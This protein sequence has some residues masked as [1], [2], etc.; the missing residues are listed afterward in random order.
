MVVGDE[1]AS[2]RNTL[3]GSFVGVGNQGEQGL[4]V[5]TMDAVDT[6]QPS[7]QFAIV[8]LTHIVVE[9]QC[10]GPVLG[11]ARQRHMRLHIRSEGTVNQ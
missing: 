3:I 4:G 10:E 2:G 9:E 6:T 11:S 5:L 1:A 7:E 8:G